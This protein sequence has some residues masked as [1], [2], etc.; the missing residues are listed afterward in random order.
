[1]HNEEP[2]TPSEFRK[3]FSRNLQLL[4]Q[5]YK[6]VSQFSR[7][8][9]IERN[10]LSRYL[11]GVSIPPPEV[12]SKICTH[13]NCPADIMIKPMDEIL[14]FHMAE[15]SYLQIIN[16]I[17]Q[18]DFQI[19]DFT[20][21][22]GLYLQWQYSIARKA[23]GLLVADLIYIYRKGNAKLWR[24]IEPRT[25]FGNSGNH[26]HYISRQSREVFGV[27]MDQTAGFCS[28]QF[29]RSAKIVRFSQ[30][31]YGY[32]AN[33]KIFP[34]S[35]ILPSSITPFKD[36]TLNLEFLEYLGDSFSSAL[37]GARKRGYWKVEDAPNYIKEI[38]GK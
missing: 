9:G 19:D 11:S 33:E 18:R 35:Y 21:P 10:K 30:Y 12:L 3:I 6:S 24:S 5:R 34:G 16:R 31:Q 38:L 7:E 32:R 8:L 25:T 14:P 20:L 26:G 36:I 23:E 27:L 37:S 1:M 28:L 2:K 17:S 22:N 29:S 15:S 13:F 4:G